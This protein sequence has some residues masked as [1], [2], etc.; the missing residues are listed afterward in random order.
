MRLTIALC[1][2]GRV[3]Q[4]PQTNPNGEYGFDGAQGYFDYMALVQGS[5]NA[6]MAHELLQL[7]TTPQAQAAYCHCHPLQSR[8]S[9]RR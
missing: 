1:W 9:R 7:V 2:D 4:G 3:Q 8:Q 5:K 6:D